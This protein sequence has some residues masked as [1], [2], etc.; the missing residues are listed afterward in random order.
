MVDLDPRVVELCSPAAGVGALDLQGQTQ[1][2][3]SINLV[4]EDEDWNET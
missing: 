1:D 2:I 3:D 4:A